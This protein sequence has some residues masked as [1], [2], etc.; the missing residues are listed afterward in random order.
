MKPKLEMYLKIH[1]SDKN[2]VYKTI[3][4]FSVIPFVAMVIAVISLNTLL[5]TYLSSGV[6]AINVIFSYLIIIN[7][8]YIV[9]KYSGRSSEEGKM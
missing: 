8:F 1:D 9:I 2:K 7:I 3:A 4:V 5:T 6:N